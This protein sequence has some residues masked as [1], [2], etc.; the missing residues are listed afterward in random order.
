MNPMTIRRVESKLVEVVAEDEEMYE[1]Y[2]TKI[3]NPT[4]LAKVF[5]HL[6]HLHVEQFWVAILDAK[7]HLQ[8]TYRVSEGTLTAALVHPREVYGPA[9]RLGAAAILVA[10]NHPSGDSTPSP[11]DKAVYKRLQEVGTLLGVPCLDSVII[12]NGSTTSME[13]QE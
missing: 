8:A 4:R 3:S 11:E 9:L 13:G 7:H 2:G 10:H 5:S 6:R 12:G 1:M